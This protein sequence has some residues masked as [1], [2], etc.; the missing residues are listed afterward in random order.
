[1]AAFK[2]CIG[3]EVSE[4]VSLASIPEM[5]PKPKLGRG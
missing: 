2:A 5:D 3:L 1:M 4:N